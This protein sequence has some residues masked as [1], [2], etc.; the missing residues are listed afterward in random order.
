[1]GHLSNFSAWP[2]SYSKTQCL[3]VKSGS[4]QLNSFFKMNIKDAWQL[5]VLS[6]HEYLVHTC[7]FMLDFATENN[8]ILRQVHCLLQYTS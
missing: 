8:W 7:S 2:G 1:M 6:F 5:V 3:P 4:M